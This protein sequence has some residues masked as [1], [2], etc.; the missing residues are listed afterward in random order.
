MGLTVK[1]FLVFEQEDELANGLNYSLFL[2][3]RLGE[4][5]YFLYLNRWVS[6]LMG[7]T[8]KIFLVL[9][10]EDEPANGLHY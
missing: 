2:N 6:L 7:F 5:V 9:E 10:Q 8:V 1:I 3:R 4:T